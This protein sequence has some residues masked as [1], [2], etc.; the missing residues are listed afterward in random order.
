M[1][2]WQKRHLWLGLKV[3]VVAA[4]IWWLV[5]SG[6]LEFRQL[7]VFYD[8]PRIFI[9]NFVLWLVFYVLLGALRWHTLLRGLDLQ[10]SYWRT[11][12]LQLIGFFFNTAM[13]GAVGGDVVKAFYVIR[14]QETRA[15][16][17]ALLTVLLDRVIGLSGLF[18]VAGVALLVGGT[19]VLDRPE[20]RPLALFVIVGLIGIVAAAGLIFVPFA[21]GGDPIV[22][23]LQS[24]KP[25][26]T[27]ALK[28][29][30]ALRIYR[31]R[32]KVLS[33]ALLISGVIH[34][35][36]LSFA[37]LV[38]VTV[39]GFK[40]EFWTM[41]LV[42]P[43]ATMTTA[44]PLAPGGLGVGHLAFEKL[45]ALV[46]WHGGANVFNVVVIGQLGLHLLGLI[47]YLM[48]RVRLPTSEEISAEL[49]D[50]MTV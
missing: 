16:T 45:Y 27:T 47:P 35:A 37:I 34:L 39:A 50:E 12:R 28:I 24:G 2:V 6:R 3:A 11:A 49:K 10:I 18:L 23:L 29:Y 5:Q 14:E 21:P 46:G 38:T 33:Q 4:L 25:G 32:P 9:F 8:E 44:V 13:P 36:S 30:E 17:P 15:K 41:A 1:K 19:W 26:M 22:K 31:T 43:L 20:I 48:H 40:P 42:Y 7:R